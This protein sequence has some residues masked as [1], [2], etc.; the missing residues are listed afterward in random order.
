MADNSHKERYQLL[1]NSESKENRAA[2]S[3]RIGYV[4]AAA[5]SAIGL[6]NIWRFPYL[7][8]R[9]GGGMFL[10]VYIILTVTFGYTLIIAETSLGRMTRRGPIGAFRKLGAG[11]ILRAGG[12]INAIVPML[13]V[14]YYSV[15]GGWV[16][17]YLTAYLSE[18]VKTISSDGYFSSFISDSRSVVLFF[19]IFSAIVFTVILSGVQKG[20]EQLSKVLMP[21]LL[22]LA[23]FVAIYSITRPG[24]LAGV[25][26][27]LI[28]DFSHFSW[29][30]VVAAMGQMFYSLSIAMGILYTYGSYLN[31]DV[32]IDRS[33]GQLEFFD[34]GVAILAGL[35]I[36]PSVFSFFDG[37]ISK[38]H[39]GPSLTFI[40][41]PQVFASMKG[42]TIVAIAFF[43][44]FLLAALT[45][46]ISLMETSIN[47][48]EDE[49]HLS[50][51]KCALIMCAIMG[52]FGVSSSL[53]Y[54]A[55][56]SV[57]ILGMAILD[58]FDFLTNSVMM[59]VAALATCVL[60][61]KVVG[62]DRIDREVEASSKTFRRKKIFHLFIRYL[63]PVFLI[64]I[65]ISSILNALGIISI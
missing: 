36:I 56:S 37:D 16:L 32:D 24:A 46:A 38:L 6:G 35:M 21:V 23:V 19:A 4:L 42:G 47:T 13:I 25:Q 8:A 64:L 26:Y 34:T 18:D 30:S 11:R 29:M 7:A 20:I 27:F 65:L 60:I 33:T 62:T 12:W 5:G 53:S 17:K 48:L 14:P 58:F 2:F 10:L 44:M 41:L 22:I 49:L 59:P 52:T 9:Y 1:Q 54:G 39:A 61:W 40:T 15:I 45:S 55:L 28:P 57:K 31:K 50:R 51:P 3:G 63:A 43:T